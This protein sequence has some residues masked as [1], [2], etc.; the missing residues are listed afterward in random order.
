VG[1]RQGETRIQRE[2]DV[3]LTGEVCEVRSTSYRIVH[4]SVVGHLRRLLFLWRWDIAYDFH[5]K[6][7]HT[8]NSDLVRVFSSEV[9]IRTRY[10]SLNKNKRSWLQ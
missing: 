4:Y 7:L 6:A 3:M 2:V 1:W 5:P 8:H 10:Q 9:Q